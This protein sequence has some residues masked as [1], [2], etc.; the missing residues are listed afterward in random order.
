MEPEAFAKLQGPSFCAYL[1]EYPM[2]LGR[3][4]DMNSHIH[5]SEDP[6]ISKTH[7]SIDWSPSDRCFFIKCI[8]RNSL[9][10]NQIR[11]KAEDPPTKLTS[12]AA[13]RIGSVE[14]YFLLPV[15]E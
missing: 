14:F 2:T 7:A 11:I 9:L 6:K 8:G 3:A 10:V 5:L 4:K 1:T 12:K 13:I 15:K